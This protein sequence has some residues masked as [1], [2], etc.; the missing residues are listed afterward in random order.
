M[1]CTPT[2]TI[3]SPTA[4][5]APPTHPQALKNACIAWLQ[6]WFKASCL[7]SESLSGSFCNTILMTSL[8]PLQSIASV[9]I[10]NNTHI[11][12]HF[13]VGVSSGSSMTHLC[14]RL[15]QKAW[16]DPYALYLPTHTNTR[17]H[18]PLSLLAAETWPPSWRS[19]LVCCFPRLST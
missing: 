3:Q 1:S 7:S 2:T 15:T 12:T 5:E 14:S 17:R 10:S 9:S 16:L 11:Q 4:S 19:L 13:E 6:V 18:T 8:Q